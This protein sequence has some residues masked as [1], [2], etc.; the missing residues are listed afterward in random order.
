MVRPT[1]DHY[2]ILGV[3]P[4]ATLDEI[5]KAFKKLSLKFHPDKTP[6]VEDHE[7]FKA[8]NAAYELIKNYMENPEQDNPTPSPMNNYMPQ[9][10]PHGFTFARPQYEAP[11]P[12]HT[13]YA[14]NYYSTSTAST[15]TNTNTN[16][17]PT[18]TNNGFPYYHMFN[19][20]GEEAQQRKDFQER[21]A[22]FERIRRE[23]LERD[24]ASEAQRKREAEEAIR[25]RLEKTQRRK[26]AARKLDEVRESVQNAYKTNLAEAAKQMTAEEIKREE[27]RRVKEDEI[28]TEQAKPV[29][30]ERTAQAESI[31]KQPG[32]TMDDDE[33]DPS[34][35]P[36]S[37]FSRSPTRE[38]TD[39]GKSDRID[40]STNGGDAS[41]SKISE[42]I[43]VSD[44]ELDDTIKYGDNEEEEEEEGDLYDPLKDIPTIPSFRRHL[45]LSKSQNKRRKFNAADGA[46]R[47]FNASDPIVLEEN[48]DKKGTIIPDIIL[49]LDDD[50][51]DNDDTNT[52][53]GNVPLPSVDNSMDKGKYNTKYTT[54]P[55]GLSSEGIH[56]HDEPMKD[57]HAEDDDNEEYDPSAV[58]I[59]QG[60]RSVNWNQLNYKDEETRS[61][62][63]KSSERRNSDGSG[64][65]PSPA[66]AS[67][68]HPVYNQ[69][70]PHPTTPHKRSKISSNGGAFNLNDLESKLGKDI[71]EVDFKDL[72]ESLPSQGKRQ[73]TNNNLTQH[74]RRAYVYS[75]GRSRAET[76]ATPLNKNSVRGHSTKK[77]LTMLDMH[78]SK[79][80][81]G[82]V[83]PTPPHM[84][85]HPSVS[86]PD[87]QSY[88]NAIIK[89][90][91]E[92]IN[93]KRLI[94]QYQKERIL[95]DIEN[96][97][98]IN[99]DDVTENFDTYT[100]C[101][102][103]D[104]I[105]MNEFLEAS[106]QFGNTITTYQQNR[107]WIQ[108]FKLNNPE[109]N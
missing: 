70:R 31:N 41:G 67:I 11:R 48:L 50:K 109:W 12:T 95:K 65:N 22:Q 46:G 26:A 94:V 42:P 3:A 23:M 86:R 9:Q 62:S 100:E 90:Q 36:S 51:V 97:D 34:Y 10:Y 17:R 39:N 93:Y 55:L 25:R 78:A 73:S 27:E 69:S 84:V 71:E 72:Y 32:Y 38:T 63:E 76:L 33:Y 85:I 89:Y 7:K 8:I 15:T 92:F 13:E 104:Y 49:L 68:N 14:K 47:G 21:N 57:I 77:K 105:V 45:S 19:K 102:Q 18:A 107:Q 108:T 103:Q 98:L 43:L 20:F 75:D 16:P 96:F 6:N 74:K 60:A 35:M 101:L 91:H 53:T 5:R 29:K 37:T 79:N 30:E 80:I 4:N 54:P 99:D 2:R 88:V 87:W 28:T 52:T 106:R 83:A 82:I 61:T 59:T 24:K 66:D 58:P 40:T 81:R 1:S 56:R 64:Y 44:S